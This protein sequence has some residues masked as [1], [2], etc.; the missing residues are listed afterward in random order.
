[1][2]EQFYDPIVATK[3]GDRRTPERGGHGT[4]WR[5]EGTSARIFRKETGTCALRPQLR[6]LFQPQDRAARF[7]LP[8]SIRLIDSMEN[9]SGS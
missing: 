1:M 3:V 7:F 6:R 8:C 5:G 2:A 9:F 4:H